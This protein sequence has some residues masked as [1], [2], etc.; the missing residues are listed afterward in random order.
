MNWTELLYDPIYDLQGVNGVIESSSGK[1]DQTL[2]VLDKTAAKDIP[3]NVI[4]LETIGPAACLRAVELAAKGLVRS[5]LDEALL[6]MN[7]RAWRIK[8][9]K[10]R[11]SPGGESDG[12]Y[13]LS[14][15]ED[16]TSR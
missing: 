8:S 3:Y 5:D 2:T 1:A 7:G 15:S 10:A 13:I 6:T 4:T 14:L 9:A 11:P 12:E 16:R